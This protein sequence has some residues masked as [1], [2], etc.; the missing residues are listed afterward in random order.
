ML[1]NLKYL[2][3]LLA[4]TVLPAD[5]ISQFY[6]GSIQDFGKNRIQYKEFLWQYYRFEKYDVYFYEGGKDL[7]A[8]VAHI[9]TEHIK[10]IENKLDFVLQDKIEF[11]IY[12]SQS[13]F[14]QSNVGLN[15]DESYNIGGTTRIVG[16]KVFF[17]YEGEYNQLLHNLRSGIAEV[18]INQMMFGG[19]WK[20]VIKNATLLNLPKWYIDGLISWLAEPD[21]PDVQ[22][23]IKDGVRNEKF[24]KF[25]WLRGEE[26]TMAGHAVWQ[27]IDEVFGR[28]VIPNVLYMSRISRNVESG[29]LFVLGMSL[30]TL[31]AEF[32]NYYI[33]KFSRDDAGKDEIALESIDYKVKKRHVYSQLKL[34]PFGDK[35]A[36]VSNVMGQYRVYIN[37]LN[38]GK[39]IKI[40]KGEHKLE[41]IVDKSWPIVTWS[42]TGSDLAY[43]IE[44]RGKLYMHIYNL[45]DK[46]TYKRELFNLDKVLDMSYS[47]DGRRMIFS[48]VRNGQTDIYLYYLIGNRQERI[49]NDFFEDINP[50][51]I[52]GSNRIIFSSNRVNDTLAIKEFDKLG[53]T[54]DVFVMNLNNRKVLER[55][56]RTPL[57]DEVQPA[58]YDSIRYTFLGS[59]NG[60]YNRYIA[61]YDSA[62]SRIDTTIH[63]RYF[64][65]TD[66]LTNYKYNIAEYDVNLKR[67]RYTQLVYKDGKYQFYQSSFDEDDISFQSEIP[68]EDLRTIDETIQE[69][70]GIS[71]IISVPADEDETIDIKNYN[72]GNEDEVIYEQTSI[73][74]GKN[75]ETQSQEVIQLGDDPVK[76]KIPNPRNYN[77][78]FTTDYATTQIGNSFNSQF[79]QQIYSNSTSGNLTPGTSALFKVGMSDL[80]EDYKITG[81][82]RFGFNF[83][84]NEYLLMYQNL[85]RRLDKVILFERLANTLRDPDIFQLNSFFKVH[86]HS[87]KYMMRYP[88]NEVLAVKGTIMARND[89]KAFLANDLFTLSRPNEYEYQ[90]GAKLELI[91]DN[92]LNLGLNLYEG[93]RFKIWGEYYQQIDRENSD[94]YVTGL[95]FRHYERIHRNLIF[96]S[97]IAGS[98]SFG[99]ERL[100]YYMGGVDQWFGA[101]YTDPPLP[102]PS[103]QNF[104]YQ[105]LALPMRGF[106]FNARNGNSFAVANAEIRFPVFKYFINKPLKS[107]FLDNFQVIGFGDVGT[108]W[109]GPDPYSDENS[110]NTEVIDSNPLEITLQ[111]RREPVIGGFGIGLRS[112]ILGYFVRADWAWGVEDSVVQP[113]VF[114]FSTSLDF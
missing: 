77:I 82:F 71:D 69:D 92:T 80:F 17:Y 81:G 31:S 11:V 6:N 38:T 87:L 32:V 48:G 56:T 20:E 4:I 14:K 44:K 65:H 12:N 108:A 26:A 54:R 94:F 25:N 55:I 97:R 18:L 58:Q 60:V 42:P 86:T 104:Q 43:M 2:L 89:R 110:F 41:R 95:D 16:S 7:A 15:T 24:E 98:T 47:H 78:N 75:A 84:N 35:V 114:Y 57:I 23:F 72:F 102:I 106:H 83:D 51:F 68:Q 29:F 96:A 5:M 49:T 63:Y 76:I 66:Q 109:T 59:E 13:D 27:Y 28:A 107:D 93:S 88:I 62:I 74:I 19:N 45:D 39:Q 70:I 9:A 111:S 34:S 99:S 100:L 112:R 103:G 64:T 85:K 101:K 46:K 33:G 22:N 3:L 113:S 61:T 90:A 36:F 52:K 8:H 50:R 21:N 91:F 67:K 1:S 73:E 105:A 10:D 79:Y 53:V 30:N 37:D 40:A